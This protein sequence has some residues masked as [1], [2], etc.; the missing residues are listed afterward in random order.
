MNTEEKMPETPDWDAIR[1]KLK[2]PGLTDKF[3]DDEQGRE[4]KAAMEKLLKELESLS[5]NA[6]KLAGRSFEDQDE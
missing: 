1:A 4:L 5:I 3:A 6:G 2:D